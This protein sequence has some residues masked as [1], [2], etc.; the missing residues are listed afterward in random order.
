MA[1][2]TRAGFPIVIGLLVLALPVRP[3]AAS[4]ESEHEEHHRNELAMFVG[5]THERRE[6]GFALAVEY[7][8]RI[9]KR[10]GIGA[11]AE[12]TWGDFDFWV[13][14]VPLTIH[15]DRWRFGIAPGIEQSD[16]HRKLLGRFAIG[17]D[18]ETARAVVTPGLS[19]DVVEGEAVYVLGV[20]VGTGF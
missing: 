20:S 10:F 14:A 17:Y 15:A 2:R 9:S 8:R 1:V 12:R 11:L 19:I 7:E 13:Y 6:N 5:V 16:G 3:A 4:E 18:F